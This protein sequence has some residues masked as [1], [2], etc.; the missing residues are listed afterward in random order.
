MS[1]K[2]KKNK[3]NITADS[4]LQQTIKIGN[5]LRH[6]RNKFGLTQEFIAG[7]I[8]I[9]RPTLNKI[10]SGK[11]EISLI[12]AKLLA[13]FYSIPLD[14]IISCNDA[15]QGQIRRTLNNYNDNVTVK[16]D[17]SETQVVPVKTL[18][19]PNMLFELINYLCFKLMSLPWFAEPQLKQVLFLIE[20]QAVSTLGYPF[21]SLAFQKSATGLEVKDWPQI[22]ES[23]LASQ[24]VVKISAGTNF[25]YPDVKLLPL[26]ESDLAEISARE[27][28]FIEQI[29]VTVGVLNKEDLLGLIQK[30]EPYKKA[31]VFKDVTL[32]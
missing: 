24:K 31:E 15:M 4:S 29:I 22:I 8:G 27:L 11:A 18:Y 1:R 30:I 19:R 23:L 6:L 9:S 14:N 17:A 26:Q 10:E 16:S 20:Y 3:K 2:Y 13:D 12:Q 21:T 5:F 25:K 32:Y 7:K 28:L